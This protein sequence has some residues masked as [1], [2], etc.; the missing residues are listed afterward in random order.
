MVLA[1][2]LSESPAHNEGEGPPFLDQ[3]LSNGMFVPLSAIAVLSFFLLPMLAS[4]AGAYPI[5]GRRSRGR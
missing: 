4:M 3:V 5:A 2:Y 1:L